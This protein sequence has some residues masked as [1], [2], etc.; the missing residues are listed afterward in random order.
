VLGFESW[1]AFYQS[2]LQSV[3]AVILV[4][5]AFLLWCARASAPA[6]AGADPAAAAFVRRYALVFAALTILD[7]ICTGPLVRALSLEGAGRTMVMLLFVALGDFRVYLLLFALRDGSA[8]IAPAARCAAGW[9]LAVP[10]FAWPTY[11]VLVAIAP[12]LPDET[13]W[14]LY[15]EAFAALALLLRH[16]LSSDRRL[17]DR[18]ML[19]LYLRAALAYVSIYYGLWALADALILGAGMG[20][21]WLLRTIPN[22]LYYAFWVPFV[23]FAFFSARYASTRSEI[24]AAR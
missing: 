11:R 5:I 1:K 2:D 23:Y 17:D 10:A 7:P 12:E 8:P 3:W 9:T 22:Q 20:S 4:P 14:L 18:P 24:Q 15:E 16:G 13:L 21:G 6:R 19:R